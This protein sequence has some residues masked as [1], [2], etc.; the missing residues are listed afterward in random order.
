MRKEG[1]RL[2]LSLTF[3]LVAALSVSVYYNLAAP[4][5][6]NTIVGTVDHRHVGEGLDKQ[7]QPVTWYTV[8]VR[9]I[10]RDNVTPLDAGQTMAY[11]VS[12]DDYDSVNA[13]DIVVGRVSQGMS[14]D[15]VQVSPSES[16]LREECVGVKASSDP[17]T[18]SE[19][20]CVMG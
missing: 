14:L 2:Y 18:P 19:H 17:V 8:S 5:V 3:V 6:P 7:G 13:N 4:F 15:I 11:I 20:Y 10:N 1:D 12:K 9:P 16:W